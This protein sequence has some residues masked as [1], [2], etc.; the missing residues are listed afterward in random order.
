LHRTYYGKVYYAGDGVVASVH[1]EQATTHVE[2]RSWYN[3]DGEEQSGGGYD[4][5]LKS[6]R[7]TL[8]VNLSEAVKTRPQVFSIRKNMND[9]LLIATLNEGVYWTPKSRR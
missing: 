7:K 2:A 4:K 5:N 3:Q 9:G 6:R 1:F 8:G